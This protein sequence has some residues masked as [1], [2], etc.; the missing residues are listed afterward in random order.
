MPPV[1]DTWTA[2]RRG[3]RVQRHLAMSDHSR[4]QGD[5]TD[6]HGTLSSLNNVGH[7]A[8]QSS[9]KNARANDACD[10]NNS[11]VYHVTSHSRDQPE[12]SRRNCSRDQRLV[13]AFFLEITSARIWVCYVITTVFLCVDSN[14]GRNGDITHF[15]WNY[16][17][18]V[19][20]FQWFLRESASGLKLLKPMLDYFLKKLTDRKLCDRKVPFDQYF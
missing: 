10:M 18:F 6:F 8:W 20:S 3:G 9:E 14:Y 15:R 1:S 13:I 5:W 2:P 19:K 16:G 4:R 7:C 11:T 17:N 12:M